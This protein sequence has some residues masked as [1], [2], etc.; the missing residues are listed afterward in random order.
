MAIDQ[1]D[2]TI[3]AAPA[4]DAEHANPD[5]TRTRRPSTAGSS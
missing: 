4:L 3:T 5:A 2:P 1:D